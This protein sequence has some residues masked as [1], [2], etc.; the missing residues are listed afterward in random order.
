MTHQKEL[1]KDWSLERQVE[2]LSIVAPNLRLFMKYSSEELMALRQS[3]QDAF[4]LF[5]S[6][7]MDQ[8]DEIKKRTVDKC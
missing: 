1:M 8:A 7:M 4:D 5:A 2:A 3:N 6:I